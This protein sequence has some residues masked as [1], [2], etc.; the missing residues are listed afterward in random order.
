MGVYKPARATRDVENPAR[1]LG[2]FFDNCLTEL[3]HWN[4]GAV[5]FP[6]V[7]HQPRFCCRFEA[8]QEHFKRAASIFIRFRWLHKI[9]LSSPSITFQPL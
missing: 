4:R 2:V 6:D 5:M 1:K 3:R 8:L 9:I 7:P